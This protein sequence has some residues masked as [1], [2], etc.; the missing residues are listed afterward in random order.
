MAEQPG[1][2]TLQSKEH[3]MQ[4]SDSQQPTPGTQLLLSAVVSLMP[5]PLTSVR[6]LGMRK[7]SY[8]EH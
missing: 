2:D 8:S 5:R 7:K 4:M 3:T 1:T 6:G